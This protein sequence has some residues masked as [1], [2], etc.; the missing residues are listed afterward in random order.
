MKIGKSAACRVIGLALATGVFVIASVALAAQGIDHKPARERKTETIPIYDPRFKNETLTYALVDGKVVVDGDLNLGTPMEVMKRS[1]DLARATAKASLE[2][3]DGLGLRSIELQQLKLL[4]EKNPA[5]FPGGGREKAA[6]EV[7]EAISAL[8]PLAT[9]R[10]EAR[11]PNRAQANAA[12]GI[13]TGELRWPGGK[14]PYLVVNGVPP[15]SQ[16]LIECAVAHWKSK[17]GGLIE[18]QTID[19]TKPKPKAHLTFA[20]GAGVCEADSIGKKLQDGEHVICLD[21]Q[22]CHVEH[23]IHEIGHIVGLLHEHNRSDRDKYLAVQTKKVDPSMLDQFSN[24]IAAVDVGPFDW[25]SIMLYP[26]RSFPMAGAQGATL[27]KRDENG[28]AID[29]VNWGMKIG[30]GWGEGVS[31]SLSAGDIAAVRKYYGASKK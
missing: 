22:D 27:K 6:Q 8:A 12:F 29:D 24:P 13:V 7:R 16:K 9:L 1:W 26:P 3:A 25:Q 5:N 19:A 30:S 2:R 10:R 21:P 28:I 18:L 31:T 20:P 4:A 14:I 15:A 11:G 17:T 23:V